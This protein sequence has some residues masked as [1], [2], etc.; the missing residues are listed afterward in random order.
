MEQEILDAF[1]HKIIPQASSSGKVVIDGFVFN[2]SFCLSSQVEDIRD[3]RMPVIQ[4]RDKDRFDK[5]LVQYTESMLQFLE[6]NKELQKCDYLYFEGN[7][8]AIIEAAVMNVWF[9][10]TEEDFREP[11]RFLEYRN[12]FLTDI[13]C[14]LECDN[15]HKGEIIDG[16]V[17][18]HYEWSI[19]VW[20]PSG[21]ETPYVFRSRMVMDDGSSLNL[22]NIG[23]GL[24]GNKAY[25]YAVHQGKVKEEPSNGKKKLNRILY[26]IN[27]GVVD[28]YPDES[29]LDVSVSS[30]A[31]LTVFL[32]FLQETACN[33]MIVKSNFPIRTLAKMNN[34]RVDQAEFVRICENTINKFYRDFRRLSYHFPELEITSYPYEVDNSMHIDISSTP[35]LGDDY[36]HQVYHSLH[37]PVEIKKK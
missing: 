31:A 12:H 1:Y 37:E 34:S 16:K 30:I 27:R 18:H 25:I 20:N 21:N 5:A 2:S 15:F 11:I 28:D 10:A 4:I 8:E 14:N 35:S 9:N 24:D 29:V 19:G 6:Q 17:P 13:T 23:F 32:S 26:Q 36:I 22:P 33:E 7:K 3:D